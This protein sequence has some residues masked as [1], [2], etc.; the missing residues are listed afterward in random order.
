MSYFTLPLHPTLI[1]PYSIQGPGKA[2]AAFTPVPTVAVGGHF[3]NYCFTHQQEVGRSFE[4]H[5][6][7]VATNHDHAFA[8]VMLIHMAAALPARVMEK[9]GM[10]N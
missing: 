1:Q 7:R 8:Q 2:H 5:T 3:I 10:S 9:R 6:G 4:K